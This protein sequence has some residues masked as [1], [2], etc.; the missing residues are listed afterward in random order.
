MDL[1]YV[2]KR[3]KDINDLKFLLVRQA[4]FGRCVDAQW[5]KIEHCKE[6]FR[7]F[8]TIRTEETWPKTIWVDKETE[9]AREFEK[10]C[11][12]ECLQ[13]YSKINETWPHLLKVQKEP[14][15]LYFTVT[16][17]VMGKS[18]F[19]Y[20]VTISQPWSPVK[21]ARLTWYQGI[22]RIPTFLHC[23]DEANYNNLQNPSLKIKIEFESRSMI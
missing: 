2:D 6:T 14:W 15:K 20:C 21:S 4:L 8:V 22:S 9:I 23:S 5:K 3:A 13:I 12:T 10:L 19:T 17:K 7:P 11:R 1:A 18:T 16:W